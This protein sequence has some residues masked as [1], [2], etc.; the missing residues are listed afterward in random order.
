MI[1]RPYPRTAPCAINCRADGNQIGALIGPDL[2]QGICGYGDT[3]PEALRALADE[4][5]REVGETPESESIRR[6]ELFSMNP[7]ISEK[8]DRDRKL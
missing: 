8:I 6:I 7:E 2:M 1:S 4:L 5:E 3:L